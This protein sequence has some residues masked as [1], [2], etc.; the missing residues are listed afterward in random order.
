M[1]DELPP[2]EDTA[3]FSISTEDGYVR[4]EQDPGNQPLY[5]PTQARDLAD[6][7]R[8]AAADAEREAE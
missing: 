4:I 3:P 5:T 1:G 8:A 2:L 6:D 7:I